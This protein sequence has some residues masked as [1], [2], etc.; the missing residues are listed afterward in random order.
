[1]R[2]CVS[3]RLFICEPYR[4]LG[5]AVRRKEEPDEEA[6]SDLCRRRSARWRSAWAA[7]QSLGPPERSTTRP[8]RSA[9]HKPTVRVPPRLA[10]TRLED[11]QRRRAGRAPSTAGPRRVRMEL[12]SGCCARSPSC[13][14]ISTTCR[15][16]L[17]RRPRFWERKNEGECA[18]ALMLPLGKHGETGR[19]QLTPLLRAATRQ[20]AWP[21]ALGPEHCQVSWP[22]CSRAPSRASWWRMRCVPGEPW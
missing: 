9:A 2:R 20:R 16:P 15:P 19:R 3:H 4:F 22:T 17:Q 5:C 14:R 7:P 18:R 13:H 10:T 8:D 11:R 6:N 12:R 1:M 21:K